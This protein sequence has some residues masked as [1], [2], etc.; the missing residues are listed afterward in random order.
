MYRFYGRSIHQPGGFTEGGA[1]ERLPSRRYLLPTTLNGRILFMNIHFLKKYYFKQI[2]HSCLWAFCFCTSTLAQPTTG[3]QSTKNIRLNQLGFY[4]SA[5]KIAVFPA[6][7]ATPFYLITPDLE[8]TVY[9]GQL[10]KPLSSPYSQKNTRLA[11]FSDFTTEGEYVVASA[12]GST[13]Y[14]FVVAPNVLQPVARGALKAFYYIRAST[15]IKEEFGGAWQRA[16]GHPDTQVQVHPSAAT[17]QR[18]A[19]TLIAAPRGWYDAGDYNK[20]VVNSGITTA[21][22]LALYE[23]FPAYADTLALNIPESSNALPDLLDEVL[24]NLR[25]MLCMQDPADG[26]VYHKL[27]TSNF[28][29]MVMPEQA[30]Q[31]RYVIQKSTAATLDFAAVMAQAAR[32]IRSF[33]TDLPGLADSCTQAAVQAW[34]WARHHPDRLYDQSALNE[35]YDPDIT[36]GAYGDQSVS[37]EFIWAAAELYITTQADSFYTAVDIFPDEAMPLPTWSQVRLLGYYSLARHRRALGAVA[38]RDTAQ[39]KQ[40]IVAFAEELMSG[41][42]QQPYHTVMGQSARDFNWGSSANAANQGIA[43][44]QAYRLTADSRYLTGA[45]HN[46]DYLLGRNATGY[47]LVT[48]YGDQP[49]LHPHHRPSVADPVADPVPGLLSGGPNAQAPQQDQCPGYT[50]TEPDATYLDDA[51]SYASNEIA[52]NWNAP[53]VYLVGVIE[54]LQNE[55]QTTDNR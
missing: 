34:S 12:G 43:L 18:P 7:S 50:S 51:C 54:V 45:L 10:S 19:G 35:R 42:D 48:G 4:P 24:W 6:G 14:P 15:S 37:D 3:Q 11:D 46:A 31:P 20:Y 2:F 33:D 23:D 25:W 13:S 53:L 44:I 27:T 17:P 40:R 29:G 9:T 1:A 16:A 26:G 38:D 30:Q 39:L 36:T 8:D 47:S 55:I 41:V 32:V 5:P 28:E 22:L 52:I 21:T 49:P